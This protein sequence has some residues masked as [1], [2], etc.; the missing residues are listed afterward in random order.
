MRIKLQPLFFTALALFVLLFSNAAQ[1]Q[2]VPPVP[3]PAKQTMQEGKSPT[4][5]TTKTTEPTTSEETVQAREAAPPRKEGLILPEIVALIGPV[6]VTATQNVRDGV[7]YISLTGVAPGSGY[8][9]VIT[10]DIVMARLF[11]SDTLRSAGGVLTSRIGGT[12]L[13]LPLTVQAVF[14]GFLITAKEPNVKVIDLITEHEYEIGEVIL[15]SGN[16]LISHI[17]DVEFPSPISGWQWVIDKPNDKSWT[18][19]NIL[20]V[21]KARPGPPQR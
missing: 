4:E 10:T 11:F 12:S 18:S 13:R 6:V 16:S 7:E 2:E 17:V 1:A 19:V 14:N 8:G 21:R 9:E 20:R 15:Y 3:P 5:Q